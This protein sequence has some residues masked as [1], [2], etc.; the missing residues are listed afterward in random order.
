MDWTVV[1]LLLPGIALIG[2][3]AFI[4][5]GTYR[6]RATVPAVPPQQEA[7]TLFTAL[8]GAMGRQEQATQQL[9]V[10]V[11]A[12]TERLQGYAADL[13]TAKETIRSLQVVEAQLRGDIRESQSHIVALQQ[14]ASEERRARIDTAAELGDVKAQLRI[15]DDRL[16][17]QRIRMDEQERQLAVLND[18]R[19]KAINVGMVWE[20]RARDAEKQRDALVAEVRALTAEVEALKARLAELEAA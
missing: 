7:A 12:Q 8:Q 1:A 19:A 20:A 2:G 14:Q 11:A 13:H 16:K 3:L 5:V 17:A 18:E 10:V 6:R 4:G 9:A 15:A